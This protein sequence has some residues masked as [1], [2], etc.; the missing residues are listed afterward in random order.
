MLNACPCPDDKGAKIIML[1]RGMAVYRAGNTRKESTMMRKLLRLFGLVGMLGLVSAGAASAED[2]RGTI[3]ADEAIKGET[4]RYT[5]QTSN[6]F[7]TM[8]KLIGNDLT[9]N[10]A[11]AATDNKT[12]YI[13]SMRSGR[14]K[15]R[16]MT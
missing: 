2:C 5:A 7:A 1:I 6:D 3:T 8:D 14:V 12:T 16:K 10:N 11:S 4:A 15:Y 9:Y 13:D